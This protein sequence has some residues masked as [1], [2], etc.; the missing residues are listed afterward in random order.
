MGGRQKIN[1][2]TINNFRL[3]NKRYLWKGSRYVNKRKT[4]KEVDPVIRF[5][6]KDHHLNVIAR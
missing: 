1:M 2:C 6:N 5:E 4:Y 3:K